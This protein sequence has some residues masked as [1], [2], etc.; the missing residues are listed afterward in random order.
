LLSVST[1]AKPKIANYPF[2]TIT[3]HLGVCH[4]LDNQNDNDSQ[5]LMLCDIPGLIEGASTG[6]GMGDTFLRHIQKCSI[7]LHIIDGSSDNP[8]QDYHTI[9]H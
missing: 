2:T 9:Q 8:I 6:I 7:L 3:P 4:L 5:S 1:A